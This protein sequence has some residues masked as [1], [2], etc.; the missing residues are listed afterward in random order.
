MDIIA[1][2]KLTGVRRDGEQFPVTVQIGRPYLSG[3]D[4][5]S[6]SCPVS[7]E[8]LYSDLADMVGIDSLHSLVLACRLAST[9]LQG[10]RAEGGRLLYPDA[11]EFDLSYFGLPPFPGGA[12]THA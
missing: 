12:S 11:T 4:P 3:E 10:F 5:E 7:V 6:W 9:L 1:Q 2:L 8:P